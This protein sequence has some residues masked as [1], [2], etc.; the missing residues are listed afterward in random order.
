MP[1]CVEPEP[2]MPASSSTLANSLAARI[3]DHVETPAKICAP[4]GDRDDHDT[5]ENLSAL[6]DRDPAAPPRSAEGP[7]LVRLFD[8][9]LS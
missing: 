9:L 5:A 6:L 3:G 2:G 7:Q 4:K 8:A 1:E